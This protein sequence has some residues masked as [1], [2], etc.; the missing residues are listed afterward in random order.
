MS[1]VVTTRLSDEV[2]AM[3]D[4]MAKAQDRSRAWVVARLVEGATSA[5][6]ELQTFLQPGLDDLAAGRVHT[7]EEMEAWF[8]ERKG[9]RPS[10]LAAE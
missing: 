6:Q 9:N 1:N 7:Q 8:A 5:E 2:L 10:R 3:V 4:A